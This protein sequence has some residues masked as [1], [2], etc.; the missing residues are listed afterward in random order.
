MAG[1]Q[2]TEDDT[3]K[4]D[5]RE[6][7]DAAVVDT[8]IPD[9]VSLALIHEAASLTNFD[10]LG[11]PE[12]LESQ[13][14]RSRGQ[15]LEQE[16]IDSD[17]DDE[18]GYEV[19]IE[20]GRLKTESGY[21]VRFVDEEHINLSPFD[22]V[23]LDSLKAYPAPE[24]LIESLTP[25]IR[26]HLKEHGFVKVRGA[27]SADQKRFYGVKM[28]WE[29]DDEMNVWDRIMEVIG[30][31]GSTPAA[32]DYVYIKDGPERWD[33][34]ELAEARGIARSSIRG[35]VRAIENELDE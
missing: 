19:T 21:V 33:V 16:R 24:Q 34:E 3:E 23:S 6:D 7:V 25:R 31:V 8:A 10:A 11:D 22:I 17:T 9:G 20:E 13:I 35:N 27:Y 18:T 28:G 12:S 1:E 4:N 5:G 29:L 30:Q 32:V 14:A 26:G 15:A 2:P